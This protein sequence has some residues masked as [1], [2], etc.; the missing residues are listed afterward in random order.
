MTNTQINRTWLMRY[1][2]VNSIRGNW[3]GGRRGDRI[4]S[5]NVARKE[6]GEPMFTHWLN[7]AIR[8]TEDKTVCRS[9]GTEL[10]FVAR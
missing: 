10:Q 5:A 2:P 3:G 4:L 7:R 6:I 8:N 9:N 1:Y